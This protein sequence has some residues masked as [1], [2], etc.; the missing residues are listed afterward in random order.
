[1]IRIDFLVILIL[2]N[3]IYMLIFITLAILSS[4]VLLGGA[5][6]YYVLQS[7]HATTFKIQPQKH[8]KN[9]FKKHFP[10]IAFNLAL[11]FLVTGIALYFFEAAFEQKLP[12]FWTFCCQVGII[13]FFDDTFF[14]FYHR[15]MHQIPFLFKKIHSIHHRASPVFPLDFIYVHPLEW[16]LGATGMTL[17][18][19]CVYW[20][21]GAINVYPFWA[22]AAFRNLHEL[23]IH[24]NL[25]SMFGQYIPFWGTTEHHDY[26]H[27][28]LNGNYAST[29][30]FWDWIFK[31]E[32]TPKERSKNKL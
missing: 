20:W 4:S 21:Y 16:M 12:S 28:K 26:H 30:R 7:P 6:S 27:S 11:L 10:L 22:Y 31:T 17:G 24:S 23:E 32:I 29:F 5:Y 14:Y 3:K 18:I 2:R 15:A 1:M 25:R 13:L 9:V 8:Q 19:V